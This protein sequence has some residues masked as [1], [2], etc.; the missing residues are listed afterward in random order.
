MTDVVIGAGTQCYF[1]VWQVTNEYS[2]NLGKWFVTRQPDGRI[3]TKG[4]KSKDT[5]IGK[6][7]WLYDK[8]MEVEHV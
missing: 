5:A 3:M 2:P 8:A 4:Y 6:A 7:R 1:V